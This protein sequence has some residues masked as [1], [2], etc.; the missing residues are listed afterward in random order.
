MRVVEVFPGCRGGAARYKTMIVQ[1]NGFSPKNRFYG[2][3]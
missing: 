2:G 1:G 3:P